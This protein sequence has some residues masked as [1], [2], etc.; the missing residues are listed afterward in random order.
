VKIKGLNFVQTC[1]A[2]PEQY[3]VF[4]NEGAIVGY[5]RLR[6][7]GLTCE[8]PDCGGELIYSTS[9][10]DGLSGCFESEEQRVTHLTNI[11]EAIINHISKLQQTGI[12]KV[13]CIDTFDNGIFG[14]WIAGRKY[15]VARYDEE[16]DEWYVEDDNGDVGRVDANDFVEYFNILECDK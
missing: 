6:W 5:I 12:K 8:Y 14:Y 13:L 9:V 10:G 11:A 4:N 3:D 1:F 2:F 7:G 15:D 16:T